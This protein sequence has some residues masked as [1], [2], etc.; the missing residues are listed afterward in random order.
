MEEIDSLYPQFRNDLR[1]H[2]LDLITNE[3]NQFSNLRNMHN[4]QP[5]F[6]A[7]YNLPS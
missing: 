3:M 5:I 6:L 2:K 1:N 4:S 7:I